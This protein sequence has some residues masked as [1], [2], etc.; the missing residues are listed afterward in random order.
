[1]AL[2][3]RIQTWTL[4][5]LLSFNGDIQLWILRI[6]PSFGEGLS[7]FEHWISCN[8]LNGYQAPNIKDLVIFQTWTL[9]VLSS[10]KEGIQKWTM[11]IQSSL[12]WDI[13]TCTFWICGITLGYPDLNLDHV[14]GLS[15]CQNAFI[16]PLCHWSSMTL[17]TNIHIWTLG[18]QILIDMG[19]V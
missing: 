6:M 10:L 18:W 8:H 15:H 14:A 4:N 3:R 19:S 11:M 5:A 12:R 13:L 2:C 17:M 16:W 7:R 9:R 1:M